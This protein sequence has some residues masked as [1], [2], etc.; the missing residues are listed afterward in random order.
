MRPVSPRKQR[1]AASSCSELKN[2]LSTTLL[3]SLMLLI[4]PFPSLS[5]AASHSG[6]MSV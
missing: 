3:T 6:Q 2:V 4:T 1:S 5:R